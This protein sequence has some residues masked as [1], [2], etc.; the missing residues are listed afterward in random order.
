MHPTSLQIILTNL[1]TLR[2]FSTNHQSHYHRIVDKR[3]ITTN[4]G[5]IATN[6][7]FVFE[8]THVNVYLVI[9]KVLGILRRWR[10]GVFIFPASGTPFLRR[11][12]TRRRSESSFYSS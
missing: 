8:R 5:H 3:Q 12:F 10:R 11:V 4:H 1:Q 6:H 9:I 2:I 7:E